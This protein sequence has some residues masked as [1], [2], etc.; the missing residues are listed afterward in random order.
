MY[1]GDHNASIDVFAFRLIIMSGAR[2]TPHPYAVT[3]FEDQVFFSDWTKMSIQRVKKY[4]GTA[5]RL[6]ISSDLSAKVLD[7]AVIHELRQP[8]G[9]TCIF[10][11]KLYLK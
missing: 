8:S 6:E 7:L 2:Y 11:C 4:N 1:I 10:S 9:M 3:V 5:T